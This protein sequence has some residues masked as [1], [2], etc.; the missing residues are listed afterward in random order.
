[1]AAALRTSSHLGDLGQ[2]AQ[3]LGDDVE[4]RPDDDHDDEA[5]DPRRHDHVPCQIERIPR[6]CAAWSMHRATRVNCGLGGL[7]LDRENA[8]RVLERSHTVAH[9]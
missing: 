2:V 3:L 5:R 4:S 9:C 8:A 1:M 7:S 6:P